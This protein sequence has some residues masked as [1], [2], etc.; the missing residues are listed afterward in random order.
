MHAWSWVIAL[1]VGLS[2]A[3]ADGVELVMVEQDGCTYCAAWDRDIAPIYPKTSEGAFA[4][5]RRLQLRAPVPDDLSF[6]SRPVLT[7]T[8]ILVESGR[9]LARIEGYPGEEMFWWFLDRLLRENT[10]FEG[11]NP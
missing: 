4:P 3:H 7:P 11:G 2:M 8:F 1:I 6:A 9:E 5:L 10:S